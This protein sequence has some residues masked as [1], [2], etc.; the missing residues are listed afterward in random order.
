MG[1]QESAP[2]FYRRKIRSSDEPNGTSLVSMGP[3]P[4]LPGGVTSPV[5]IS[6]QNTQG[7]ENLFDCPNFLIC[8]T[9]FD[10]EQLLNYPQGEIRPA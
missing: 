5:Y 7:N 3:S 8:S 1:T 2:N 6:R 9:T 10:A 4:F